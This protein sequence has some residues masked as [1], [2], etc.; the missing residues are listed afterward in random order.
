MIMATQLRET[1]LVAA[2][3]ESTLDLVTTG[4]IVKSMIIWFQ[5]QSNLH[6]TG[7]AAVTVVVTGT[8]GLVESLLANTLAIIGLQATGSA[9]SGVGD[10]LL[11]LVLGGLGGVGNDLL[12][13]LC[14]KK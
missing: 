11:D 5:E 2:E 13:G 14:G 1:I 6:G 4:G 9:V 10:S 12:L 8:L 7:G 3:T